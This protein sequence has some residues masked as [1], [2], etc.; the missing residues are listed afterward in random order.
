[1]KNNGKIS[2]ID[3]RDY[4]STFNMILFP[5]VGFLASHDRHG[6]IW[7]GGLWKRGGG[8]EGID[9]GGGARVV[10]RVCFGAKLMWGDMGEV[11]PSL[12]RGVGG[13]PKD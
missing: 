12:Y 5:R 9:N 11:H 2:A 7:A 8:D 3:C 1:M 10:A 13:V 4:K 6:F